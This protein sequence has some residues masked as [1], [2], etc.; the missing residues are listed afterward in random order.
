MDSNNLITHLNNWQEHINKIDEKN[1][2]LVE[3]K[4]NKEIILNEFDDIQKKYSEKTE[5]LNKINFFLIGESPTCF[6]KYI[7]NEN[8]S[9]GTKPDI[10]SDF[11]KP[12]DFCLKTKTD[13]LTF[14]NQKN[15]LIFDIYLF[16][17][18]SYVY[19]HYTETKRFT[20]NNYGIFCEY[21]DHK[22]DGKEIHTDTRFV[23]CFSKL[24]SRTTYTRFI[25][26][27]N[28]KFKRN[29]IAR[30]KMIS[31]KEFKTLSSYNI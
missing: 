7:Y 27:L 17:F 3:V 24:N 11:L 12:K 9:I 30:S 23:L 15:I 4:L 1:G 8:G 14:F 6:N 26:Y 21:W 29:D 16:P 5:S 18:P 22:L 25:K 20:D 19:N 10:T 2:K 28:D 31:L 13:L